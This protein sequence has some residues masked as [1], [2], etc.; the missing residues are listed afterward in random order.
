M[1]CFYKG[2]I[3][4]YEVN[5]WLNPGNKYNGVLNIN[6]G[7]EQIKFPRLYNFNTFVT[8]GVELQVAS[9]EDFLE[10]DLDQNAIY[11]WLPDTANFLAWNT[12]Q[13]Y[14]TYVKEG[15]PIRIPVN[16]TY[17]STRSSSPVVSFRVQV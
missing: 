10:S 2:R 9:R 11:V 3:M 7:E 5:L 14:F 15:E 6:R 12:S 8:K 4:I 1:L 16:K 17:V 13:P